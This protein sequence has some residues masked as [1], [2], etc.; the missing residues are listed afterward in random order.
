MKGNLICTVI[1]PKLQID[2]PFCEV[3]GNP[4]SIELTNE[5]AKLMHTEEISG[6]EG[7]KNMTFYNTD[8]HPVFV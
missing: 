4:S 5:K 8:L 6:G 7:I 2:V 1:V 3:R